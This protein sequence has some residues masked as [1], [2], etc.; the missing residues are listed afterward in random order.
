[1]NLLR[2][3]PTIIETNNS[4]LTKLPEETSKSLEQS[5][6]PL[7]LSLDERGMIQDCSKSFEKQFGFRRS[8]LVWQPVSKLFPQLV[9]VELI[10]SGQINPLL[11]YLCR[12][13]QLYEAQNRHGDTLSCNLSFVRIEYNGKRFLRLMVRPS[14]GVRV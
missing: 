4:F 1:M 10:K 11:N 5:H 2:E 14:D 6:D 12:C 13:G 3:D 7:A 8:E 9:G